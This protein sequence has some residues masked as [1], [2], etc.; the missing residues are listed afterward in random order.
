MSFFV[1]S[2]YSDPDAAVREQRYRAA[3]AFCAFAAAA[4]MRV[5]SPI[6]HWHEAAKLGGLPTDAEFWLWLNRED[7]A[8]SAGVIVLALPGWQASRGVAGEL[9]QAARLAMNVQFYRRG[10]GLRWT[11]IAPEQARAI[12]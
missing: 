12:G 6:V 3:V 9:E 1:A 11:F 8:R 10:E 7:L 5:Y 4:R 2:P